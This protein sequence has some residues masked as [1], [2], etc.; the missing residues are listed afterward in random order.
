MLIAKYNNK[1]GNRYTQELKLI[2]NTDFEYRLKPEIDT[3]T[4]NKINTGN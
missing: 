2:L 1:V 4:E 3:E